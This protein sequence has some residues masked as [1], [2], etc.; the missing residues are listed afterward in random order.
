MK[1]LPFNL[2]KKSSRYYFYF[3]STVLFLLA[4]CSCKK[5]LDV[6]DL[7]DPTFSGNITS[8]GGITAFAKGGVYWNGFNY[9]DGWL[10]DSYFSLPWGYHE[11]MGDVIGGGQ[12]S[13]NQT[14]TIGVPDAFQADPNDPSTKFTN[15]S[16]Q[17]LDIVRGFN[18]VGSTSNGNNAT[19]YEWVNMYAMINGCNSTLEHLGDVTLSTDKA[20]TIKA[21]AYWWKGYAYAQIGTLYYAG[22]I[23]DQ[24]NT[25]V[26]KYV[27]Q[28]AIIDESN[29]NLNLAMTTLNGITNQ[30]DY[31]TVITE[32]IPTQNQVG[33]GLP[34]TATQWI[35][36]I[37][38]MLARNI[39]LNHLDPCVNN[40]PAATI[41]KAT[42]TPMTAADWQAVISYCN[43]GIQ[44]GD[45][46]FTGR[47]SESNSYFS[48]S[49]GSVA[50]LLTASNQV[51][52]YKV[53]ERLVQQFKP[54]D[55]RLANFS[56][57][58]GTFYGDANTNSTRWTLVD[59]VDKELTGIPILGSRTPGGL[60]IYIGPTY[61][62]NALMLA[63]AYIRTGDIEKGLGYIDEVRNAQG[64]GV[65]A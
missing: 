40:N 41:S 36:T 24:S 51:T 20:N 54:D 7:N 57:A 58:N 15:P 13:N 4:F 19:Y 39:V 42:I 22:L 45:Y 30:G 64:A 2:H 32:L 60:E 37:N 50:G 35:R 44:Q 52:T 8:E 34:P 62:E 11:L 16:P 31:T 21:W 46:V 56:T 25:I 55:K 5:Q 17:A 49:G 10:G 27:N 26:N 12:G 59:G 43:N 29:K 23:I 53:S 61:E 14:T 3:L 6:N 9:G 18:N 1:R 48:P 47:T 33:L 63:E 65:A 28:A 38:T